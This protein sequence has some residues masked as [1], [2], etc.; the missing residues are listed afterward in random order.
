MSTVAWDEI[1]YDET[2]NYVS[3]ICGTSYIASQ[4]TLIHRQLVTPRCVTCGQEDHA[5][6][7]LYRNSKGGLLDKITCPVSRYNESYARAGIRDNTT[8]KIRIHP[9]KFV[10]HH[11]GDLTDI[12]EAW[13]IFLTEGHESWMSMPR[14][15]RLWRAILFFAGKGHSLETAGEP[16]I[17]YGAID[18]SDQA[19]ILIDE[20]YLDCL[21]QDAF[22]GP[23]ME[24][25]TKCYF[26]KPCYWCGLDDH[27][28]MTE[29][30]N[31]IGK[32]LAC[33]LGIACEGLS[34]NEVLDAFNDLHH[35]CTAKVMEALDHYEFQGVG[36]YSTERTM[37]EFR[38]DVLTRC[39]EI[40]CGWSFKRGDLHSDDNF[41]DQE[42]TLSV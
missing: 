25:R 5:L 34:Y 3:T 21:P 40:R 42:D 13:H 20:K 15:D 24:E 14:I 27:S 23:T 32:K 2:G 4:T 26:S 30:E 7:S 39:D 31:A 8:A 22:V 35:C 33:P 36:W 41:L 1:E 18:L 37:A 16:P 9:W 19:S 11:K 38:N 10:T 12:R 28:A 29:D 6:I 17:F